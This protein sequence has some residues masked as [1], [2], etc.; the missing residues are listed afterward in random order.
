M[1][2]LRSP[3]I[4]AAA[5]VV[6]AALL[7][8]VAAPVAAQQLAI[9]T[10]PT[11]T[12]AP[13]APS[14]IAAKT[15]VTADAE[16][17]ARI[18]SI[19]TEIASLRNVRV[20]VSAGVVTLTGTVPAPDDVDRAETIAARVAGVVTVQNDV[21]RDLKVDSNLTP[22]L[23]KF[24]SDLRG[25]FRALPL[26]GVALAI[27]LMIGYL[28]YLLASIDRL[29]RRIS[30]N[31]FLAELIAT[32]IRAIFVMLGIVAGL[33][34]LG[35]TALLGAVLGGAGVI[36]IAIGFAVRDTVDNYVS[37]LMLSLRQ[38]FRANDHVVIEASEG[39]VVR[40]TSRATILMTLDGNHLR[41]P[42][43]TVFKAVILNYTRNPERRF[44]FDLGVDADDDPIA[45]MAVGLKAVRA[46]DFVLDEPRATA[47]IR[48]VGDSNIVL[49]FFGW[50][51]Q[52]DTDFL[53]GRSLALEAAKRA[54]EGAGFALPEPIYRLRFDEAAPLPVK[55]MANAATAAPKAKPI[56]RPTNSIVEDSAP[57]SHVAQLVDQERAEASGEDLLD[58]KR[59]IE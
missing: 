49:R 10:P 44:E 40:L 32:F 38:P 48:D 59:P 36:G 14:A 52:A 20:R 57:D 50:I 37:S 54:L 8:M 33:E 12:P 47:I 31:A 3:G 26:I 55:G 16:I 30:P 27:A 7:V 15:N 39:R 46:L 11:E 19:F 18:T 42:N 53:K 25:L 4:I 29:W 28:G 5:G 13:A 35:A 17:A 23:G 45:G 9:T 6:V 24:T 43:S 34:V 2:R 22:V 56:D 58:S 41:I 1:S 51:D 21:E